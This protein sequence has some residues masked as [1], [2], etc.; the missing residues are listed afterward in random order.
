MPR[1]YLHIRKGEELVRD[2]AGMELQAGELH[3]E[4]IEAARDILAEGDLS[5][6]D[7]RAW[8]FEIADEVGGVV[9]MLPSVDAAEPDP[10]ATPPS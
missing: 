10:P 6:L 9:L 3:E 5:G 1:F 7:R 8:V 2:R 4:A